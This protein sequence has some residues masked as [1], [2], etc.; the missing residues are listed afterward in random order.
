MTKGR[1][2]EKDVLKIGS[3]DEKST[4]WE[5]ERKLVATQERLESGW[6]DDNSTKNGSATLLLNTQN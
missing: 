4:I 3:A 5:K 2:R 1:K 6:S